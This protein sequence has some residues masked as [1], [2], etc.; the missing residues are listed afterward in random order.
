MRY[1]FLYLPP[2]FFQF[3]FTRYMSTFFFYLC[4]C[5]LCI[6]HKL[7]SIYLRDSL[8]TRGSQKKAKSFRVARSQMDK[9]MK[10]PMSKT[11]TH[12]IRIFRLFLLENSWACL[13]IFWTTEEPTVTHVFSLPR[14][15]LGRVC[16][17]L[18]LVTR[19]VT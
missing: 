6:R 2:L 8:F 16:S 7:P 4:Y 13:G 14:L 11:Q 19:E 15:L 1:F 10:Y 18:L 9:I 3:L 12:P 17:V 5:S